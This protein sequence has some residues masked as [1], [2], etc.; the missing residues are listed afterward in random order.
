MKSLE[1]LIIDRLTSTV[2]AQETL[3]IELDIRL[4]QALQTIHALEQE[5]KS[6]GDIESEREKDVD[7]TTGK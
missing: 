6:N 7:T 4:A 5:A 1:Q 2:G 3:I